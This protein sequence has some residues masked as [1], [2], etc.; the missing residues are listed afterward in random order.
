MY[1]K[2]NSS[3]V[4][5]NFQ[6][7]AGFYQIE[8]VN[9]NAKYPIALFLNEKPIPNLM[10]ELNQSIS[11]SSLSWTMTCKANSEDVC[12]GSRTTTKSQSNNERFSMDDITDSL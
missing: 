4:S 2:S 5:S 6:V 10:F 1:A 3:V 9:F 8:V 12:Y 7:P 11:S